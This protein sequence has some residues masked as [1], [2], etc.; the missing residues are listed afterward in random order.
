MYQILLLISLVLH[1]NAIGVDFV[2]MTDVWIVFCFKFADFPQNEYVGL[3][4]SREG[5]AVSG[6]SSSGC[7]VE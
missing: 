2:L 7:V 5:A 6:A 4:I 3:A 1:M